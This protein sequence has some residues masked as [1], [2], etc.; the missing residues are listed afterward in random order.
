[1]ADWRDLS[2][3]D[4]GGELDLVLSNPPYFLPG[5]S[6]KPSGPRHDARH[7]TRG[8]LRDLL[9]KARDILRPGG[10]LVLTWPRS[11]LDALTHGA[12]EA[13]LGARRFGFPAMPG[14]SLI[15]AEFVSG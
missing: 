14:A 8:S 1:M 10:L 12:S 4:F 13:R 11:R 2:P 5:S 3:T 6:G 9:F 7:E 15:L